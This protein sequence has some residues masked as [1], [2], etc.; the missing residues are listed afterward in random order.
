MY[1]LYEVAFV[2]S[3]G[4]AAFA[5]VLGGLLGVKWHQRREVR[6]L[7]ESKFKVSEPVRFKTAR[8]SVV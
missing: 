8:T 1:R 4:L 7:L 2:H 3:A 5:L 6:V